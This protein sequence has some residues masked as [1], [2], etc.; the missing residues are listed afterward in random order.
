MPNAKP[1]YVNNY[2]KQGTLLFKH[3]KTTNFS[4]QQSITITTAT[5]HYKLLSSIEIMEEMSIYL[6][7]AY[8]RLS[9]WVQEQCKL[10]AT[11]SKS[12]AMSNNSANDDRL[13]DIEEELRRALAALNERPIL[14]KCCVKEI[15]SARKN[16]ILQRFLDALIRGPSKRQGLEMKAYDSLNF[17]AN[18]MAWVHQAAASERELIDSLFS[19]Y[20]LVCNSFYFC[21]TT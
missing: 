2:K 9:R 6:N 15:T 13:L 4:L 16:F 5:T 1:F 14:L 21:N 10:L 11:A 3:Q 19:L 20:V 17:V 8:E 18:I 7:H 12:G